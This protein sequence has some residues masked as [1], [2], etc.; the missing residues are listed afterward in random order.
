MSPEEAKQYL[1]Q[2]MESEARH[3]AAKMIKQI[4]EE[5]REKADKKAKEILSLAIQRYAG[6]YVAEKDRERRAFADRR[7]EG[8]YHRPRGPQYPRH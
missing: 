1:M 6:D 5:A 7:N 2:S 8:A 4:E 3:D